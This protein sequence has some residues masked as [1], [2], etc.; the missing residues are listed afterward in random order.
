MDRKDISSFYESI[1]TISTAPILKYNVS[2]FPPP[3]NSRP[4][5]SATKTMTTTTTTSTISAAATNNELNFYERN[6]DTN[7][8]DLLIKAAKKICGGEFT[9]RNCVHSPKYI[10]YNVNR[11]T[12]GKC[13]QC[14]TEHERDNASCSLEVINSCKG[15]VYVVKV[16]CYRFKPSKRCHQ[17]K[18]AFTILMKK[19][20][21]YISS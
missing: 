14:K 10:K 3:Y 12:A 18:K 17:F 4:Q 19:G 20:K 11:L 7:I 15:P 6:K 21:W 1:I 16:S 8:N 5:R 13:T 9:V 2:K